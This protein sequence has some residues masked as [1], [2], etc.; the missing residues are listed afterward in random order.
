M[1][2]QLLNDYK[3][4]DNSDQSAKKIPTERTIKWARLL[5][6]NVVY[7]II[8]AL[9]CLEQIIIAIP[10]YYI[11]TSSP[12]TQ[13]LA[14][15]NYIGYA[16]G[17]IHG[18]VF[19]VGVFIIFVI[20]ARKHTVKHGCDLRGYFRRDT[21]N[22][23]TDFIII[24]MFLIS[25]LLFAVFTLP[26]YSHATDV[27]TTILNT[28]LRVCLLLAAGFSCTLVVF[29]RL[30][31][32]LFTK[33]DQKELT[34]TDLMI[35]FLEFSKDL[36]AFET[37]C[38][39]ELSVENYKAYFDLKEYKAITDKQKK[40]DMCRVIYSKYIQANCLMEVNVPHH[41]RS[42]LKKAFENLQDQDLETI[43]D[44]F[45]REVKFNLTDTFGRFKFT[46][47]YR[48]SQRRSKRDI[49]RRLETIE[50]VSEEK[51]AHSEVV[52]TPL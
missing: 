2:M 9:I 43:Y 13:T 48:S 35:S 18:I 8:F 3:L 20:D 34:G 49:L 4:L 38:I 21:L 51:Y 47:I 36:E 16:N 5:T 25:C 12:S 37:Y 44:D 27:I 19:F 32:V 50:A 1:V 26:G 31:M 45:G 6:S 41:V 52:V 24:A 15:M 7:S 11:Y 39:N 17:I 23:R 28:I 14:T 10:F 46:D 33:N 22:Y 29:K 30:L 40:E 42:K